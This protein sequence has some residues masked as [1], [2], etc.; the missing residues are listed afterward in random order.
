M[1]SYFIALLSF[2]DFKM[3]LKLFLEEMRKDRYAVGG[4]LK[5]DEK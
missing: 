1:N 2:I 4:V 3:L 5:S